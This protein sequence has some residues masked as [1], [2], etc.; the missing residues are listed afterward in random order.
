M[1]RDIVYVAESDARKKKVSNAFSFLF[2]A[3]SLRQMRKA[4]KVCE[5][6]RRQGTYTGCERDLESFQSPT[7]LNPG[8]KPVYVIKFRQIFEDLCRGDSE[9]MMRS[10]EHSYFCIKDF[11]GR[12]W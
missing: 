4:T 12:W 7:G 6:W 10:V 1:E 11:E 8:N 3:Y 5:T 2:L 9:V